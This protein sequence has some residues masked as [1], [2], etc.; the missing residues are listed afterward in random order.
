MREDM[1]RIKGRG[2]TSA[3]FAYRAQFFPAA[4]RLSGKFDP[5]AVPQEVLAFLIEGG[6]R[7]CGIGDWRVEKSGVF[8][9]FHL[10]DEQEHELWTKYA[11]GKGPVPT[12]VSLLTQAAAE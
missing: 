7:S 2:G 3:N 10:A 4:I 8:G 6:G 12:P 9:S 1:V 11:N 5:D